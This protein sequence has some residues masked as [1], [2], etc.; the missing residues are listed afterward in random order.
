MNETKLNHDSSAYIR[1]IERCVSVLDSTSTTGLLTDIFLVVGDLGDY[2]DSDTCI[3]TIFKQLSSGKNDQ[4]SKL[5]N[6]FGSQSEKLL[7]LVNFMLKDIKES[8]EAFGLLL[9][10]RDRISMGQESILDTL[11]MFN[12]HAD[13]PTLANMGKSYIQEYC[14]LVAELQKVTILN[15]KLFTISELLQA[16]SKNC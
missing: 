9:T 14:A 1:A 10:S 3:G 16:A 4:I 13:N 11:K 15:D 8:H 5:S 2:N 6:N 12:V 7:K